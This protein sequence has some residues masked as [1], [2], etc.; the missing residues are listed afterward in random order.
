[1]A[2]R[3]VPNRRITTEWRFDVRL[4]SYK[5]TDDT[6]F[7]PNPFWGCMTLATC[8]PQIRR[9]KRRGDWIAGFTSKLLCGDPVGHERLVFLMQVQERMTLAEYFR[10]ERF[11]SK[12]PRNPRVARVY[13]EGD[14]IYRPL[15]LNA[16]EAHHFEQLPNTNHVPDDHAHDVNGRYVLISKRFVY[17]GVDALPIPSHVRPEVP[18]GQSGHGT[19][20]SDPARAAA[21]IDYVFQKRAN[22]DIKARPHS[23]PRSDDS[24]KQTHDEPRIEEGDLKAPTWKPSP[25]EQPG[26]RWT[27]KSSGGGM[28]RLSTC[29]AA[30]RR[31]KNR[32]S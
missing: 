10:D 18:P 22:V 5:M 27:P 25:R 24:W 31:S 17:F 21:F 26:S 13:R 9:Y 8:K 1:M 19:G 12:I 2:A 6:G 32:T 15:I 14:N 30:S 3:T 7:A 4:F 16:R 29:S 23:W 11:Q 28:S 20:T